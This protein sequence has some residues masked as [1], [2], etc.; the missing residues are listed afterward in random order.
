MKCRLWGHFFED[1]AVIQ[2]DGVPMGVGGVSTV[3]S[4]LKYP[5]TGT[6][7]HVLKVF[8]R[9]GL[10]VCQLQLNCCMG[11]LSH[12]RYARY[13]AYSIFLARFCTGFGYSCSGD[14]LDSAFL[15]L[16]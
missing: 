4:L 14:V 15:V 13:L 5:L 1:M 2:W 3:F 6:E 11:Q 7:G 12:A 16:Y 10:V 8:S 9:H